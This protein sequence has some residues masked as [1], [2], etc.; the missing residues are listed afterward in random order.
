M[1]LW[2]RRSSAI[3][4]EQLGLEYRLFGKVGR[5]F[6]PKIVWGDR[7]AGVAVRSSPPNCKM[8]ACIEVI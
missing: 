3:A 2:N 8:D 5:N 1:L 6:D 4:I 7:S